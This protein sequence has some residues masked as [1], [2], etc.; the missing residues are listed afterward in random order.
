MAINCGVGVQVKISDIVHGVNTNEQEIVNNKREI[1]RAEAELGSR[2]DINTADISDIDDRLSSVE[3]AGG[4]IPAQIST[5]QA[6]VQSNTD[7]INDISGVVA[8]VESNVSSLDARVTALEGDTTTEYLDSDDVDP[9]NPLSDTN[10]IATIDSFKTY[11]NDNATSDVSD[12]NRIVTLDDMN[13]AVL[14]FGQF[15]FNIKDV[16]A[17]NI[18]DHAKGGSSVKDTWV[19]R[20]LND[21]KFDMQI[22]P[23]RYYIELNVPGTGCTHQARLIDENDVVLMVGTTASSPEGQNSFSHISGEFN[24]ENSIKVRV[25]TIADADVPDIGLGIGSP[26]PGTN[27]VYTYGHLESI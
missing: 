24:I 2:I 22:D 17:S 1:L 5:L 26:F 10:K 13:A 23:G 4:S 21:G 18:V 6:E 9:L 12:E 3:G 20:R 7:A 25:E 11:I 14:T 15:K 19:V 8:V 16:V 27:S